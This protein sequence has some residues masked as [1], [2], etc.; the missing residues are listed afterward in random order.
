MA[1]CAV[2]LHKN[3]FHQADPLAVRQWGR[4]FSQLTA[5]EVRIYFS[6]TTTRIPFNSLL[7]ERLRS[8][9]A[10]LRKEIKLALCMFLSLLSNTVNWAQLTNEWPDAI[11]DA[12]WIWKACSSVRT[13]VYTCGSLATTWRCSVV[14][15]IKRRLCR[16]MLKEAEEAFF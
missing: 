13:G 7:Q 3:L 6:P 15:P 12:I 2:A 11:R 9:K 10:M 8:S 1:R 4:M 5:P 14:F 16:R